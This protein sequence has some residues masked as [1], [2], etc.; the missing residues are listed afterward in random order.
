VAC[1]IN[2]ESV[3]SIAFE[4]LAARITSPLTLRTVK[5]LLG[6]IESRLVLSLAGHATKAAQIDHL[7]KH[8]SPPSRRTGASV[9]STSGKKLTPQGGYKGVA[10]DSGRSP[11]GTAAVSMGKDVPTSEEKD[12]DRYPARVFLCAY[13]IQG[14]PDAV[15]S[16]RGKRETALA[17]AAARLLPEFEALTTTI[18]NGPST[19]PLCPSSPNSA[20]EKLSDWSPDGPASTPVQ[21]PQ[22]RPFAAQLAAFDSAWCSYLYQFVAW[23]VKD[24]QVLEADL[25]R[26]ACQLELSMLQKCKVL[27]DGNP[28]ELSH[29]AKAIRKQVFEDQN[30]LRDRIVHLTGS[31][32]LVRLENALVDTRVKFEDAIRNGLPLPSPFASP[33]L[34]KSYSTMPNLPVSASPGGNSQESH[35]EAGQTS[36]PKAVRSL[37]PSVPETG[38]TV[39]SSGD[40]M[41]D[42][43]VL[44]GDAN[45]VQDTGFSNERIVNEML[46]DSSQQFLSAMT[47][48]KPLHPD[49]LSS[50]LPANISNM[51]AQ[52]RATM[53][54]AFWD[55]IAE[56]LMKVPTGYKR[57]VSLV[58]EVRDELEVLVPEEWKI[59]LHE[60]M[61]LELFSQIL[62]S[63]SSNIEYLRQLLDY[64]AS[65][66]LKLGA[67]IRDSDTKAAHQSLVDELSVAVSPNSESESAFAVSLVKGVRFIFEQIQV[68]KQDITSTRLQAL[69]PLI[70]GPAGIDYMRKAFGARFQLKEAISAVEIIQHLP[71]TFHWFEEVAHSLEREQSELE[72]SLAA[73]HTVYQTASR[74]GPQVTGLPPVSSM[75]TGG[76]M[77]ITTGLSGNNFQLPSSTPQG[78]SCC[79]VLL[80]T[81]PRG[82]FSACLFQT[83]H[84]SELSADTMNK[85]HLFSVCL[86][87]TLAVGGFGSRPGDFAEGVCMEK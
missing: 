40:N 15:F 54:N 10:K 56:D 63:G 11:A 26:M 32:G 65:L 55:S 21:P 85:P 57:I 76:Q 83:Y 81:D 20:A 2:V 23:K 69:A 70:N 67:P 60:S 58:G 71:H 25:T 42:G 80:S 86:V 78:W 17:A 66:I 62:E 39:S 75:R 1:A 38:D 46:H 35:N 37:F 33:V 29:D 51:Q 30:L 59:E 14:Q 64:A 24:A 9:A 53:E 47:Q 27:P 73:Q 6:R 77:F 36:Q 12:K 72:L 3:T 45:H 84:L 43:Q 31:A 41:K 16:S 50:P 13:M 19:T 5:A 82:S 34:S 49:Y 79:H 87:F 74:L 8:L 28:A 52:V 22:F 7:L 44:F 18:L 48:H 68:L 61:D 4:Q